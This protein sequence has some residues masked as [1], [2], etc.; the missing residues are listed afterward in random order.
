MA[1]ELKVAV[2]QDPSMVQ[3]EACLA[4]DIAI[5]RQPSRC[6]ICR[7]NAEHLVVLGQNRRMR[8]ILAVVGALFPHCCNALIENKE[9]CFNA[10]SLYKQHN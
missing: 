9:Y 4:A 3:V 8:I 10:T 1:L 2:S 7:H 6:A 5:F